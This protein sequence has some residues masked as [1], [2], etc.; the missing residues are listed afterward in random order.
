MIR[1]QPRVPQTYISRWSWD[2]ESPMACRATHKLGVDDREIRN[3]VTEHKK[4]SKVVTIVNKQGLHAR[5]I[6][7]FVDLANRFQSQIT[8]TKGTQVVDGKSPMEIMLLE[9]ICGTELTLTTVGPDAEQAL[10]AL[11]D[12]VA[13]RFEA[14]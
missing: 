11:A 6:M 5:P 4:V 10:D 2:L 13:R 12:L 8:I 9:A 7:Q 1:P 3:Q 14:E